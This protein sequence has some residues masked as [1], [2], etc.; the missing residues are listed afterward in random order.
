[1]L[2][3]GF[4]VLLGAYFAN[5]VPPLAAMMF[6]FLPFYAVGFIQY[7]YRSFG[8]CIVR[9]GSNTLSWVRNFT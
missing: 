4:T 3:S 7:S 1:M 6:F 2:I 5:K 9:F 8:N